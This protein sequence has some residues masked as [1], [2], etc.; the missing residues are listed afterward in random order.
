MAS[1][2]ITPEPVTQ[3]DSLVTVYN[4]QPVVSSRDI[5]VRFEKR[6][7][8]I[9]RDIENIISQMASEQETP[10]LGS[11]FFKTEYTVEVQRWINMLI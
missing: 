10:I 7:D 9:V 2:F 6:H 4:N 8:H 5:A 11:L 1:P 3:E